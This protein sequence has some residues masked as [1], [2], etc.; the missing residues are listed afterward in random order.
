MLHHYTEYTDVENVAIAEQ[1]TAQLMHDYATLEQHTVEQAPHGGGIGGAL[2]GARAAAPW[3][4]DGG[5][6][7]PRGH[8]PAVPSAFYNVRAATQPVQLFPAF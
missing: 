1:T 5:V 7:G 2:L 4:A 8:R 6:K 3:G